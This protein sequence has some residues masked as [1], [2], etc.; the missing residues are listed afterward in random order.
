M[1]KGPSENLLG[2]VLIL[3]GIFFSTDN[4][5]EWLGTFNSKIVKLS[6]CPTM[7]PSFAF[8]KALSSH[9]HRARLMIYWSRCLYWYSSWWY[10][11]KWSI[12][13][14]QLL[15]SIWRWWLDHN[16]SI[17]WVL[18]LRRLALFLNY[19]RFMCLMLIFNSFIPWPELLLSFSN[20]PIK[21]SISLAIIKQV[22]T[23]QSIN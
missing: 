12:L 18:R 23:L 7:W 20:I 15:F 10:H 21:V 2:H 13:F 4:L 19:L 3:E 1:I 6:Q 22:L 5:K 17:Y 11:W 8:N 9:A 16:V 14:Q